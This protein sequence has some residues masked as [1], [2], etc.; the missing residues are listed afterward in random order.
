M[1]SFFCLAHYCSFLVKIFDIIR[2]KRKLC[3]S[4]NFN[5]YKNLKIKKVNLISIML[6]CLISFQSFIKNNSI[7]NSFEKNNSLV[8]INSIF[9]SLTKNNSIYFTLMSIQSSNLT[10]LMQINLFARKFF[11]SLANNLNR[12]ISKM[13]HSIELLK[14]FTKNINSKSNIEVFRLVARLLKDELIK[15]NDLLYIS[16]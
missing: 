16:T 2:E 1:F 7:L 5:V 9:Q 14:S 15:L 10:T 6:S 8:K 11:N 13:K 3:H 4:K 12:N